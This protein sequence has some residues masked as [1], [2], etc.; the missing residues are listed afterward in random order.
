LTSSTVKSDRAGSVMSL[1]VSVFTQMTP[2]HAGG[3]PDGARVVSEGS[4]DA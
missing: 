3:A 4:A 1:P 2:S